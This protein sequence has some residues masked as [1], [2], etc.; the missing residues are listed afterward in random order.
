MK[1]TFRHNTE[2][3][4]YKDGRWMGLTLTVCSSV[5]TATDPASSQKK[6]ELLFFYFNSFIH[7]FIYV[8]YSFIQHLPINYVR[9]SEHFTYINKIWALD[10]ICYWFI[11]CS[12]CI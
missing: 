4:N 10:I 12:P 1:I 8:L 2:N 5:I 9:A 6:S 3:V 11:L 7:S